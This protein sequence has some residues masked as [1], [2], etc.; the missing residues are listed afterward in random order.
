MQF[1]RL[2]EFSK[3]ATAERL[4]I[5]NDIPRAAR[6][7]IYILVKMLLD[8]IRRSWG[9]PITVTSGYRSPQLNKAV[10]GARYSHHMMGCAA[11]I[12][13]GSVPKN[14][15]LMRHIIQMRVRKEIR[16]TQL[17][18]EKGGQWL[19]ISYVP[20]DL[21]NEVIGAELLGD[22]ETEDSS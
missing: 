9:A 16:F 4:H 19:H 2:S 8:P 5:F 20:T 21:K 13:V 18:L 17:I 7:L 1:F 11:D 10:G 6:E 15:K 12:S 14:R 3:S 22:E